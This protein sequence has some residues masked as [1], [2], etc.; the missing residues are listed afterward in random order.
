MWPARP[1]DSPKWPTFRGGMLDDKNFEEICGWLE[2]LLNQEGLLPKSQCKVI[3]YSQGSQ[4]VRESANGGFLN[5]G[6]M[7]NRYNCISFELQFRLRKKSGVSSQ[8]YLIVWVGGYGKGSIMH[9]GWQ[10]PHMND[11][12]VED[13]EKAAMKVYPA[14]ARL[15]YNGRPMD[16]DVIKFIKEIQS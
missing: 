14:I 2:D 8:V 6:G 3:F 11:Y 1:K 15:V 16:R 13:L 5:G 12:H 9:C 10:F 7:R 4:Y